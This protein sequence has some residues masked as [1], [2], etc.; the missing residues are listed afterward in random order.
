MVSSAG[1]NK[2]SCCWS[3]LRYRLCTKRTTT[4]K[5]KAYTANK[6]L[7]LWKQAS[8]YRYGACQKSNWFD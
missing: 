6:E 3:F 4:I 1:A 2:L 8:K 7:A 5:A